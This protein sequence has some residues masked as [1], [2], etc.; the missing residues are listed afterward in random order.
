MVAVVFVASKSMNAVKIIEPLSI[1][2][3]DKHTICLGKKTG[4]PNIFLKI[5]PPKVLRAASKCQHT[6]RVV[7]SI[8]ANRHSDLTKITHALGFSGDRLRFRNRK[9]NQTREHPYY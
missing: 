8:N 7:Y 2:K 1:Q 5:L 4:Y 9:Q 6:L 3:T